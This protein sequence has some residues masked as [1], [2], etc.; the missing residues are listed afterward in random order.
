M[1][2]VDISEDFVQLKD[3]ERATKE[4]VRLADGDLGIDIQRSFQNGEGLMVRSH[5]DLIKHQ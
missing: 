2:L 4:D 3:D 5:P 1:K